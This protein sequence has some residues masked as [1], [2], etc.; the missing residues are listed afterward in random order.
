MDAGK[1]DITGGQCGDWIDRNGVIVQDRGHE[2]IV[3]VVEDCCSFGDPKLQCTGCGWGNHNGNYTGGWFQDGPD[4][5]AC[6]ASVI[7]VGR[8]DT[9]EQ[10]VFAESDRVG[11]AE[12]RVDRRTA[13]IVF[14]R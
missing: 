2:R 10:H 5:D 8:I 3:R 9:C 1:S 7:E 11:N 4:R 6:G 13:A 14:D 12:V